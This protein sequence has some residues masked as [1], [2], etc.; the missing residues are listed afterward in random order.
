MSFCC[1]VTVIVP[2]L[3]EG[4]T[5]DEEIDVSYYGVTIET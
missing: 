1:R 2:T 4:S 5:V 3:N